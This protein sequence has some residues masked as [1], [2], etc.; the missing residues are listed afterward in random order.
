MSKK[1]K[2]N[3]FITGGHLTPAIAIYS[4][5]K[6]IEDINIYFI[7]VKHTILFD[8]ALSEEYKF[9]SSENIK[10][11]PVKTGKIYRFLSI[12]GFISLILI[13]IGFIQSIYYYIIYRPKIIVSF[14]S[15]VS[16]P[17]SIIGG[18]FRSTILTHT[19]AIIPGLSDRITSKF[20]KYVFISFRESEKYFNT[21]ATIIYTGN[22][23]RKEIF[24]ISSNTFDFKNSLP[25]IYVTGGNQG[26]HRINELIFS[27][28][29]ILLE[30]YNIVHQVGS[31]TIYKDFEKSLE[32]QRQF[33]KNPGGYISKTGIWRN[34][35]GK[36]L[37]KSN[38]IISRAGANTI[39]EILILNKKAILIPL[40]ESAYKEQSKNAKV[41]KNLSGN[42]LVMEENSIN[43]NNLLENIDKM[44]KQKQISRKTKLPDGAE[45]IIIKYILKSY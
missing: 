8:R 25:L 24:S 6:D 2:T 18:I 34:E 42:I 7:G 41:A 44:I 12:K 36:I 37:N 30:R 4:K 13:P 14:G 9:A 26:S 22:I 11:L 19:Q 21:K 10:F 33:E 39:Y 16:V 5:I 40:P 45:Y 35:I 1:G 28:L 3:I 23:V 38:L 43:R 27:N 32:Y 15:Y 17:I 31:N 29:D 20:A